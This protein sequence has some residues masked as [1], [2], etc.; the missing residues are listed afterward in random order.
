MYKVGETYEVFEDG[1]SFGICTYRGSIQKIKG[2]SREICPY[3][4]EVPENISEYRDGWCNVFTTDDGEVIVA[5]SDWKVVPIVRDNYPVISREDFIC[6]WEKDKNLRQAVIEIFIRNSEKFKD[7]VKNLRGIVNPMLQQDIKSGNI[8]SKLSIQQGRNPIIT[9]MDTKIISDWYRVASEVANELYIEGQDWCFY[10]AMKT[11]NVQNFVQPLPSSCTTS[12]DF[13]MEWLKNASCCILK[14][15]VPMKT[16]I[17]FLEHHSDKGETQSEVFIPAGYMRV[18][19]KNIMNGKT[20]VVVRL[21]PWTLSKCLSYI[22]RN[23]AMRAN[24]S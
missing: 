6:D 20:V 1:G 16:P 11:G 19:K 24:F 15:I 23:S 3:I 2:V 7:T 17:T 9:A 4:Y 5:D 13:A 22:R 21:K 14:V 8:T 18:I 12:L 10:R